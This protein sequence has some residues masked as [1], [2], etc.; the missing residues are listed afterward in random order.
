MVGSEGRG[1]GGF[2]D[3][4]YD[5]AG[6]EFTPPSHL[7]PAAVTH[8]CFI[9]TAFILIVSSLTQIFNQPITA[10]AQCSRAR[11]QDGDELLNFKLSIVS[12]SAGIFP[13]TMSGSILPGSGWSSAVR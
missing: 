5:R 1:G 4:V 2:G 8:L 13:L 7:R 10:A 12:G 3:G 9:G 6:K 11:R